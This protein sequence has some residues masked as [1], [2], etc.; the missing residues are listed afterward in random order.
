MERNNYGSVNIDQE[1]D[2]S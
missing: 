2:C 1:Y